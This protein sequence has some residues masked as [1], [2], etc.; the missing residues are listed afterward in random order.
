MCE[1]SMRVDESV[2]AEKEARQ[3]SEVSQGTGARRTR[4]ASEVTDISAIDISLGGTGQ[5]LELDPKRKWGPSTWTEVE[6]ELKEQ[7]NRLLE[8]VAPSWRVVEV[9]VGESQEEADSGAG[10]GE[11][12]ERSS[13]VGII[14]LS[15]IDDIRWQGFHTG[16]ASY[17]LDWD[18]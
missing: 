13:L 4:R 8:D 11:L 7:G 9:K 5:V 10:D 3:G 18:R 6:A 17:I 2:K 16:R 14:P 1:M 12:S 15:H